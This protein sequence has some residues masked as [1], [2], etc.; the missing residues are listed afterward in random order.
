RIAEPDAAP[1]KIL[2]RASG[3]AGT[4][5]EPS[6]QRPDLRMFEV[7]ETAALFLVAADVLAAFL[8]EDLL[9][10]HLADGAELDL[11]LSRA[12]AGGSG[13]R[14]QRDAAGGGHQTVV[15]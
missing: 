15:S 3:E 7:G 13:Q 2:G 5:G 6:S 1:E 8:R 10:Q 9:G 4:D 14:Q 11:Q 12:A